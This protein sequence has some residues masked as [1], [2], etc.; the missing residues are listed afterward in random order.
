[1]AR[2]D[3]CAEWFLRTRE[4]CFGASADGLPHA[5]GWLQLVGQPAGMLVVLVTGGAGAIA[6]A[7]RAV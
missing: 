6:A 7:V 2:R 5:G 4:V 1:V 3:R